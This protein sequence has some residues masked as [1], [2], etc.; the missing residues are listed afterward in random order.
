MKMEK[1]SALAV[2]AILI[3]TVL[4]PAM[5]MG[6]L[7]NS[8]NSSFNF[9]E[10][11][12][13]SI[14]PVPVPETPTPSPPIEDADDNNNATDREA[15]ETFDDGIPLPVEPEPTN[16]NAT[17]V[18]TFE[19]QSAEV[20]TPVTPY[21]IYG[22]VFYK[23]G[24]ACNNFTVNITNMNNSKYWPVETHPDYS[25]YQLIL[26][27]TNISAGNVL[28]F[29]ATDGTQFNVT[30]HTVTQS[31]INNG[32]LFN[33]NLTLPSLITE[34]PTVES[35]TITPDDE[36]AEEGVQINP[37]PGGNK[38]VNISAVVS[39]PNG[40]NNINTVEAVI[41][42][43]GIVADS[44]VT[45]SFVSNSTLMTATYNGT[46]NMS[47]Y[48]LNGKYTV[49]VTATDNGSLT[50][51]N[52]TTFEYQTARALQLDAD[53]IAFGSVDPNETSEVLGDYDMTT[54]D[55]ATVRNTG[56][57]VI[58]V[59]VNG[60]N[61][62]ST[63]NGNLI[64]KDNIEAQINEKSYLD[65]SEARCFDVNMSIGVSSLKNADFKLYVPY[66]T[67]QGGYG[68][69]ITLTATTC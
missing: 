60:T 19:V 7:G 65:M 4:V 2:I 40:W 1:L 3:T 58:D 21:M 17:E 42:G 67:P 55:N 20:I 62:T 53:T 66:G 50:G 37:T 35:I 30:N 48:Y 64:T 32:G 45:L 29:N 38:T 43:P 49:N 44:P 23:N 14:N 24:T 69:T 46:F 63:S 6:L 61:M 10:S 8:S 41:T 39:D 18:Q 13:E 36:P 12:N 54:L 68:G 57:V 16:D 15:N 9:N 52:S 47:F 27:N 26:D 11:L 5:G 28:S 34:A 51:S 56:N 31:D 33:F 59:E 25:F 22:W